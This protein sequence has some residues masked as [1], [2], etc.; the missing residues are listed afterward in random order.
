L[1]FAELFVQTPLLP[2]RLVKAFEAWLHTLTSEK[3]ALGHKTYSKFS[4]L[5]QNIGQTGMKSQIYD[6]FQREP[7]ALE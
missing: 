1:Q 2:L 3:A 6:T 7:S 5:S 4:Q